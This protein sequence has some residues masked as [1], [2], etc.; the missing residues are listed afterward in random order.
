MD[1]QTR[2][3]QLFAAKIDVGGEVRSYGLLQEPYRIEISFRN[4]QKPDDLH[5]A[6]ELP[7]SF[8]LTPDQLKFIDR[9]VPDLLR[10]DPEFQRLEKE[11]GN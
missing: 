10:E 3:Q 9:V 7:T 5:Q 8:K 11:L 2:C 4:I 1:I 6:M